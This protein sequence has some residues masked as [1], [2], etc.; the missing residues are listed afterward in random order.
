MI[1]LVLKQTFQGSETILRMVPKCVGQSVGLRHRNPLDAVWTHGP[2]ASD[3]RLP[4]HK[5]KKLEQRAKP[6]AI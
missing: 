4:S 1:K 6:Y 3:P 5:C 2:P